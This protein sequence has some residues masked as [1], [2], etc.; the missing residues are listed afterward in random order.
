MRNIRLSK[1]PRE[2]R[3]GS[4]AKDIPFVLAY[5]GRLQFQ[6]LVSLSFNFMF[7]RPFSTFPSFY[8]HHFCSLLQLLF[9]S[10]ITLNIVFILDL[11]YSLLA[12]RAACY[13]R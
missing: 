12:F 4:H 9:V 7:Y 2:E 3:K 10:I 8:V 11:H 13:R 5:I 6:I 1:S